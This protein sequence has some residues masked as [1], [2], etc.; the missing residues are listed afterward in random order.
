MTD[1]SALTGTSTTTAATADA[2]QTLSTDDF[3]QLLLTELTNQDPL[4]PMTNQDLLNQI[5]S[6]QQLQSNKEMMSSF[7]GMVDKFDGFIDGFDGFLENQNS[8]IDRLDSF[9]V[10]QQLNS[11]SQMIGQMV[12]GKNTAGNFTVGKVVAVNVEEGQVFLTLDTGEKINMDDMTRLGGTSSESLIG[13]LAVGMS[14]GE[15]VVGV[16]ESMEIDNNGKVILTL[17]TKNEL[18]EETK[19]EVPLENISLI[20]QDT[21]GYLI[22]SQVEGFAG[23]EF[24]QGTV[25]SYQLQSDG[26]NLILGGTT[27]LP[28]L[29][30]TGINNNNS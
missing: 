16:V 24:V 27:V 21:A 12:T 11:A 17:K 9:M 23:D 4:E 10:R 20:N 30:L 1:V 5:S 26:V 13:E 22:G 18:G 2:T 6:I 28:L 8:S 3:L 15:N 25:T 7:E 29:G 14:Q 19:V